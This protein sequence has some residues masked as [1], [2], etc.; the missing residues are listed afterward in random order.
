M[1]KKKK[2]LVVATSR[3]VFGLIQV[4]TYIF[5]SSTLFPPYLPQNA[6]AFTGKAVITVLSSTKQ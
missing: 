2:K 1:K 5:H 6:T 4:T 3:S